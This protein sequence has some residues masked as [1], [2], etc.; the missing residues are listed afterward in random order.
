M[1]PVHHRAFTPRADACCVCGAV[2][3]SVGATTTDPEAPEMI[4]LPPDAWVG[5]VQ[6]PVSSPCTFIN[7]PP[8]AAARTPTAPGTSHAPTG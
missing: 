1:T 3:H 7:S 6:D 5:V 2:V 4:R 8:S